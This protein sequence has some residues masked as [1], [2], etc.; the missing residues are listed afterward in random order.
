MPDIAIINRSTVLKDDQVAPIVA[1][2]QKQ[3]LNDF[4]PIW[5][6]DARLE[7]FGSKKKAPKNAWWLTVFDNSDQADA[8][9]YHDISP[10]G[11]P[12]GKAF[13]KS[14]LDSGLE[15]S[16]TISHELL[17]MLADPDINLAAQVDELIYAYEVC[18]PCEADDFGYRIDGVLVSDFV[19][20]EWFAPTAKVAGPYD[21]RKKIAKPLGLL[22][23]GYLQYL[24]LRSSGG[25]QQVQ[26]QK[27]LSRARARVG[28]RR[29]RRRTPRAEWQVSTGR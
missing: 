24:D 4:A 9:G 8:L 16:T 18:D 7:F 6:L 2:L 26:A 29:E 5:G 14:D 10:A 25:W 19:T 3:V 11:K 20:P 22:H 17:E 27:A 12:L 1:A 13:A 23:G 21:F 15:P 28:S